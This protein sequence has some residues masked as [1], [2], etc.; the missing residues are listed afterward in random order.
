MAEIEKYRPG[1]GKNQSLVQQLKEYQRDPRSLVFVTL[2][3]AY[4]AEGLAG[5]ALEILSE[6]LEFHPKLS[7]AFLCKSKCFYDLKR[8]ADSLKEIQN[9]LQINPDNLRALRFQAEIYVRL[10]Q[11]KSAIR[12]LTRVVSLFPQDQ[13][14]VQALEEL[15]NLEFGTNL[16]VNEIL[17]ASTDQAPTE[18]GKIEEF[19]IGTVSES[20]ASIGA[21]P[22]VVAALPAVASVEELEQEEEPTFA[23]RTIA[24]L[25][26]RQGLKS[27]AKSVIRK[28]LKE[29]PAN[30]WARETL[31]E[32]ET[33]GIVAPQKKLDP[34]DHLKRKARFLEQLLANVR[35]LKQEGA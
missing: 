22:G 6:G 24:E 8:Y 35:L 32:L 7:S 33:D 1:L 12:A 9:A 10:G 30:M 15:E 16:P 27:K 5:Q 31:Q 17:R 19:Q 25:Y 3:E 21:I 20:F 2:A 13:E 28:I 26:L 29:D 18:L 23:T 34:K 4:R 11:R 14:A